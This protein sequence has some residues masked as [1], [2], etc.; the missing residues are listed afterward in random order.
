MASIS[1]APVP[2][3]MYHEIGEPPET[4]DRL[5]VSPGDFAR[6][7][8]YLH[9]AGY[10][11]I[12]AGALAAAL[13][14][15]SGPLPDRPVVLTFDDGFENFHSRALPL[16][17][18]YGFTATVFMTSGWV[19]DAGPRSAGRRP[20]RMLT[21]G[22]L[23]E[24][25][26]AGMEVGAHSCAHP[27]LDQLPPHLLREELYESKARLEDALGFPVPGMAYPFGYYDAR[28]RQVV[29]DAGYQYCCAVRNVIA[30]PAADLFAVPRL[31]VRH[32]T[33]MAT[34]RRLVEGRTAAQLVQDRMLTRGYAVVRQVRKARA[35]VAPRGAEAG[36]D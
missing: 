28:V 19:A 6:Q 18:K 36:Q 20:G 15:G 35:A 14:G 29:R 5:A 1:P 31:T 3:L 8:A 10:T 32:A 25:A 33:T 2:V 34:F 30:G 16:L 4:S 26:E 9:D 21:F 12:T 22:Q 7:I 13:D 11:T 17:G 24:V 27:Q 23:A